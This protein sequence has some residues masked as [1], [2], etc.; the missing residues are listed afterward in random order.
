MDSVGSIRGARGGTR[1]AVTDPAATA[2]RLRHW[3]RPSRGLQATPKEPDDMMNL[4]GQTISTAE[5]QDGAAESKV[6]QPFKLRGG[7]YTL[8][9]L[10]LIDLKNPNFFQCRFSGPACAG[11]RL[12]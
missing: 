10:Q 3:M 11:R 9:V 6:A 7:S 8:L 12:A 1:F 4:A 5:A 2:E